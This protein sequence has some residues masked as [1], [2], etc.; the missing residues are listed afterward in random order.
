MV[1]KKTT[2]SKVAASK[3][4]KASKTIKKNVTPKTANSSTVVKTRILH[5]ANLVL[6]AVLAAIVLLMVK[7]VYYALSLSFVTKDALLSESQ[8]VFVPAEKILLDFDVRWLLI[9]MIVVSVVYSALVLSR[10][11]ASYERAQAG[12]VYLWRWV[13]LAITGAIMVKIAAIVSGVEDIATLKM[14]GGFMVSAMVFAWLSE[15][16]NQKAGTSTTAHYWLSLVSG[17]AAMSAIFVSLFGTML[18]GMIRFPW[19]VYALDLALLVGFL[20]VLSNLR[21]SN[22]RTGQSNDYEFVE[23]NYVV[24][25]VLAQF[26]FIAIAIAG[27]A[28]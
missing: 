7:P 13:M 24:T 3:K 19:Y 1:K 11:R 8:T 2:I 17:L 9:S 22:K 21:R 20:L 5:K 16:Q 14:A 25:V 26:V 18:Y 28:A 4:S 23:R 10:W 27:L 15:R 6:Q 12:R